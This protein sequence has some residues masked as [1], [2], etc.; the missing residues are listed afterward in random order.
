MVFQEITFYQFCPMTALANQA[1]S[2]MLAWYENIHA[3][4][5]GVGA[6]NPM[7]QNVCHKHKLSVNLHILSTFPNKMTFFPIFPIQIHK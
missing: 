7:G 3:Q 1:V 2:E 6:N 5:P 4:S